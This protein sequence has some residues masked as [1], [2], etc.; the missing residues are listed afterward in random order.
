MVQSACIC[1]PKLVIQSVSNS[2]M[3]LAF[4]VCPETLL[5]GCIEASSHDCLTAREC[6]ADKLQHTS[7]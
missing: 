3:R 7:S 6:L 4:H 1:S 5:F 2:A